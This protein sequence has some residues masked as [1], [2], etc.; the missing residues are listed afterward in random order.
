MQLTL[1]ATL[2]VVSVAF[3]IVLPI[4]PHLARE[5]GATPMQI[6]FLGAAY[7]A[8]Q[9]LV[10]PTWGRLS[11]R[12]G[13]KPI[14]LLG[15]LGLAISFFIMALATSY[16][17]LLAGRVLGGFLAAATIPTAQALAADLSSPH[18]RARAMGS[19]GAAISL[20]FIFGPAIGGALIPLG[21]SAPLWAGLAVS[22]VT[23]I[24]ALF[25]LRE[26]EHAVSSM[27]SGS[28]GHG[29]AL[30]GKALRGRL[31][32]L[33]IIATVITF[34]QSTVLTLLTLYMA[35]R[36]GASPAYAGLAF[37]MQSTMS[38]ILQMGAVGPLVARF[39]ESRTILKAL[40]GGLIGFASLTAAP[41]LTWATGSLLL[42]V[43][44]MSL[45]RPALGSAISK[46]SGLPLGLAMGILASFESAGRALGPLWAGAAYQWWVQGP[47]FSVALLYVVV[48][49]L[50][51]R[52]LW[53]GV[54]VGRADDHGQQVDGTGSPDETTGE[55]AAHEAGGVHRTGD[56]HESFPPS[57]GPM[58]RSS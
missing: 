20:G 51:G 3:G 12:H 35:D 46:G 55:T 2:W 48:L 50:W 44:G 38:L 52:A 4:L 54:I 28:G 24:V 14:L 49:L 25:I 42:S 26:P 5:L 7:A 33:C 34:G 15:L 29:L 31:G 30:V 37:G 43:F 19:V 45:G 21:A 57:S 11:D 6:G 10:S 17:W 41:S 56:V 39:G 47:F 16:T 8:I 32:A 23:F 40:A 1:F 58:R 36:Y 13:R 9:F 53:H 27:G 18:E 22:L